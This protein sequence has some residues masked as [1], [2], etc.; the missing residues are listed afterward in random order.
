MLDFLPHGHPTD[1][2]PEPIAQVIGNKYFS[3]LEVVLR[4]DVKVNNGDVI[5]IG[6]EKREKVDHIKGRINVNKLTAFARSELPHVVE[7]IVNKN[8]E[9]FVNFFNNA[10][11]ISTRMHQL[12]LLP[13]IGKKH[14]WDIIDERK[15]SPFKNFADIKERVKLLQNP[16][17]LIVKRILEEIE[18]EDEKYMVF[19]AR[20]RRF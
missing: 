8:E 20:P 18:N 1:R 10:Q 4:N 17:E 16:R 13:G 12:E 7:D 14:M 19:V 6:K 3:L 11:P 2:K 5:Y 15:K 9:R